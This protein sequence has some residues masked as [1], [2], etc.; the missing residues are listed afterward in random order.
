M[1]D[2]REVGN[3]YSFVYPITFS[4]DGKRL[5]YV[6]HN[7]R[8]FVVVDGVEGKQYDGVESLIFSPDSNHF[9]YM[10]ELG[11]RKF[12]VVDGVEGKPYGTMAG[13]TYREYALYD[14]FIYVA[15][16]SS[17]RLRYIPWDNNR[18]YLVEEEIR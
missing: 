15:F 6:V 4:P 8:P 11:G 3:R 16:E 1:L 9:A 18:L 14:R 2:G 17:G 12:V 13:W 10:A 5:A 7:P